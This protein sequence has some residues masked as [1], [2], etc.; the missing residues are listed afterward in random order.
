MG[1][2]P[3]SQ[4]VGDLRA[5]AGEL[6]CAV[7]FLTKEWLAPVRQRLTDISQGR[8]STLRSKLVNDPIW[9]TLELADHEV[10]LLDSPLI[11]RMRG[12]RQLGLAH[13]V[14]PGANHD[15]FEHICGVVESSD[16][17][18]KALQANIVGRN[19]RTGGRGLPSFTEQGSKLVRLAALL[20]DVG[21]GPFSHAVEPVIERRYEKDFRAFSNQLKEA[22]N[23]DAKVAP[24]E[25][26]SALI[27]LSEAM[28]PIL[29]D[30]KFS[31]GI[32]DV[33]EYQL[34]IAILI[35]GARS[36][37]F[38]ACFSAIISSQVDSDK[39]D[40]MAR[41]ALH[42]GMPIAFDTER[43]IR[44]LEVVQ[45][46]PD[47]LPSGTGQAVNVAFARQCPTGAYSDLAVTAS[48]V[49]ALEQMLIGRA[50]LYDRLYHHHK[51]RAADAMAQ[52]LYPEI[53]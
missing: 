38:E 6:Y 40:Y 27:V 25:A 46:T 39:L 29:Q 22:V 16:R 21:H 2:R 3:P 43:L 42:T 7:N 51:V 12:V 53:L 18:F 36:Y 5:S 45:C 34:R 30:K 50:F 33:N 52:R 48:G 32:D 8:D 31:V 28:A 41:D 1:G 10:L 47:N 23:L 4:V 14:F 35:L 19:K 17:M 26:I 9:S 37:D 24:A 11:Q 15:R 13:L 20:H 44:K 49:G